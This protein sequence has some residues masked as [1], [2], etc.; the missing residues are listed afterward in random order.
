MAHRTSRVCL[1]ILPLLLFQTAC[2]DPKND[3]PTPDAAVQVDSGPTSVQFADPA[4][5][6]C[7]RTQLGLPTGDLQNEHLADLTFLECTDQGITQLAGLEHATNLVYLS[8]F[9]NDITDI[10][11]LAPMT[12]LQE[13]Q[14]S[15]NNIPDITALAGLT[16]LRRLGLSRNSISD[17]T[18]LASAVELRY[19][20]L[21]ENVIT[22]ISILGGLTELTWVTLEYNHEVTAGQLA[23]LEGLGI[24]TYGRQMMPTPSLNNT[25]SAAAH[26]ALPVRTTGH[27]TLVA[28]AD[29]RQTLRW[30]TEHT[31]YPVHAE[32]GGALVVESGLI[33]WQTSNGRVAVGWSDVEGAHLCTGAYADVCSL[34]VGK[35]GAWDGSRRA[36][37]LRTAAAKAPVFTAA[38]QLTAAGRLQLGTPPPPPPPPPL[39]QDPTAFLAVDAIAEHVL[40]SPNQFDGGSCLYMAHSGAMEL[41]MNQRL[42]SDQWD[43]LGDT[44]LSERFLMN[45][46]NYVSAMTMPYYMTDLI[47]TYNEVGGSLLSRDYPFTVG[48][49]K[50]TPDGDVVRSESSDPDAYLSCS[51]NWFDDL[52]ESWQ[53]NLT[54]TPEAERTLI[55]VDP[56]RGENSRWNVGIVDSAVVDR[57]KYELRTKNAPVIV[58]YNHYLYWHADIIVGYDDT[59]DNTADPCPMVDSTLEYFGQE[60]A[61]AYVTKIQ[62]HMADQR[63][64]RNKGIFYVRDSIYDGTADEPNY[65]YMPGVVERYSQRIITRTYNWVTY[66]ANHVYTIQRH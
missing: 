63:G 39:P 61:D 16:A 52:P 24:E 12:Q 38:L 53:Q 50:D 56:L 36:P 5:E 11:A 33:H 14:L 43:Y 21:D 64:C 28:T 4:L 20:N 59:V 19:L 26:A 22:D 9:E 7:V 45:A 31:T 6:S 8:L 40:A 62:D 46:S 2:D 3:T 44:D 32:F 55:F 25:R 18:A 37:G 1:A 29:G 30:T 54:P 65:T 10:S 60:G 13:L 66:L 41:L 42:G 27:L 49:V 15:N 51:Y 34:S 35:K 17:I 48:Y 23:T 58:V 57:I 47:Y